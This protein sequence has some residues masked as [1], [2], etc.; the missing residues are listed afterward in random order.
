MSIIIMVSLRFFK[1]NKKYFVKSNRK[2]GLGRYDLVLETYR[3]KTE[4]S[5]YYWTESCW[6]YQRSGK[7]FKS[8]LEQIE[9]F[10]YDSELSNKG[11]TNI[12]RY[13]LLMKGVYI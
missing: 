11:Y 8:A 13:N 7:D 2:S 4:K 9:K 12:T 5:I 1:N 3:I 6:K 10:H